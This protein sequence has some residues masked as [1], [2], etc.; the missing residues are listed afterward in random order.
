MISI[1][2]L[3]KAAKRALAGD[4][5]QHGWH[6]Q[7]TDAQRRSEPE[8]GWMLSNDDK[9][10]LAL[11]HPETLLALIA[12]VRAAKECPCRCGDRDAVHCDRCS[13]LDAALEPFDFSG[14]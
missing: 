2:A 7:P 6:Q 13:Y 14:K 9:D 5:M 4:D 1:D 10:Y 12:C 8:G 11:V 3:E